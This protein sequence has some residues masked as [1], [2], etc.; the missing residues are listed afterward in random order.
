MTGFSDDGV[1]GLPLRRASVADKDELQALVDEG[2]A[3]LD[4][5]ASQWTYEPDR[6]LG[7]LHG[8]FADLRK[9]AGQFADVAGVQARSVAQTADDYVRQRPWVAAVEAL[10]FGF[11]IGWILSDRR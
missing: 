3:L 9:A 2:R 4:A 5:S 8:R 7:D 10:A 6:G 11:A 1:A